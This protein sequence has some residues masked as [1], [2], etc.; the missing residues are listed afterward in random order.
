MQ[1]E[2]LKISSDLILLLNN[3]PTLCNTTNIKMTCG[4][5]TLLKGLVENF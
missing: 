1:Q 2:G 3:I 4:N 5:W